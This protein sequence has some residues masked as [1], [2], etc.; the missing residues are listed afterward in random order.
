[1][2]LLSMAGSAALQSQRTRVVPDGALQ[3]VWGEELLACAPVS[4]AV[5]TCLSLGAPVLSSGHTASS[6][7]RTHLSVHALGPRCT[8][9]SVGDCPSLSDGQSGLWVNIP[10]RLHPSPCIHNC[11]F[12][13]MPVSVCTQGSHTL[14]LCVYTRL[15]LWI[16]T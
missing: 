8:G 14:C 9:L 15:C 4:V 6:G 12:V 5:H 10:V 11:S 3:Y 13:H 7:V 16:S 2:T 1:M